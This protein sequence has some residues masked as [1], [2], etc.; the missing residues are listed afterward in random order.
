M[1]GI[2]LVVA[3]TLTYAEGHQLLRI[4]FL[5]KH[6]QKHQQADPGMTFGKFI[7]IHYI[8]P[9]TETDD[10]MQD[11]QLPLRNADFT[12]LHASLYK[13]EQPVFDITPPTPSAQQFYCYN[14]TNKPLFRAFDIFQPP[15]H[16]C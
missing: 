4:P 1:A 6:F 2:L 12:L 9:V 7:R 5:V 8:D 11:Q 15:R 13:M 10:F 14:E 3:Y 16:V